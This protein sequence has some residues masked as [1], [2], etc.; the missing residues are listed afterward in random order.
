MPNT[1]KYVDRETTK[2]VDFLHTAIYWDPGKGTPIG[3]D[4][5]RIF[6][7]FAGFQTKGFFN[8][9]DFDPPNIEPLNQAKHDAFI[10]N[11]K[12][13]YPDFPNFIEK[14]CELRNKIIAGEIE[15]PVTPDF[16]EYAQDW[17]EAIV[18][19][20]E[21]P[22]LGQKIDKFLHEFMILNPEADREKVKNFIIQDFIFKASTTINSDAKVNQ[23]PEPHK[24]GINI[25]QP[26]N[27]YS[28]LIYF[29][30]WEKERTLDHLQDIPKIVNPPS[31]ENTQQWDKMTSLAYE[32]LR[33]M[34][35]A[36]DQLA[37]QSENFQPSLFQTIYQG[38]KEG[39]GY[40]FY[41]DEFVRVSNQYILD[42]L[43]KIDSNILV[44]QLD[45]I[46][47]MLDSMVKSKLSD[48]SDETQTPKGQQL[49]KISH[50]AKQLLTTLE[51]LKL[52]QM[53]LEKSYQTSDN[54]A[55]MMKKMKRS[56]ASTFHSKKHN[57]QKEKFELLKS[58]KYELLDSLIDKGTHPPKENQEAVYALIKSIID[59]SSKTSRVGTIAK[60]LAIAMG[61]ALNEP[62]QQN[63]LETL[64]KLAETHPKLN[65][66][67]Q[68][69]PEL[70]S[71]SFK[72]TEKKEG[73]DQALVESFQKEYKKIE[74]N[75][76]TVG[77]PMTIAKMALQRLPN[78]SNDIKQDNKQLESLAKQA[79]NA[80]GLKQQKSFVSGFQ[81]VKK[82]FKKI[83]KMRTSFRNSKRQ[84]SS[85]RS[86]QKLD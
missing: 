86:R 63:G 78:V 75:V 42:E 70:K 53:S 49:E 21:N 19:D 37:T 82:A 35:E 66:F 68:A 18:Q 4:R 77:K 20:F 62:C 1:E 38:V 17:V 79:L 33:S 40:Q 39:K 64:A 14:V 10:E 27:F 47:P 16:L 41:G 22:N 58:I 30:G 55:D 13:Q 15:L 56:L 44:Q 2:L 25:T 29:R 34:R 9:Y 50:D 46:K 26:M 48:R 83:P 67:I 32:S 5:N 51:D 81:K 24:R 11:L 65:E 28:Y 73:L 71:E 69:Y 23:S 57:E 72:P 6:D 54:N 61:H 43:N 85:S 80:T 59:S 74:Q 84:K 76:T 8:D 36:L 3:V 7:H 45:A 52:K 12:K 60:E 31:S